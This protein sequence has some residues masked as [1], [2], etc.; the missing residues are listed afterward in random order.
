MR[1]PRVSSDGEGKETAT[2]GTRKAVPCRQPGP[3]Y[4]QGWEQSVSSTATPPDTEQAHSIM[5]RSS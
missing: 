1:P 2:A 5:A 4:G 3:R